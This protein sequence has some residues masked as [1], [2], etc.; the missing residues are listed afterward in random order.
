[1]K[2]IRRLLLGLGFIMVLL[3]VIFLQT[4][5]IEI[6]KEPF[7]LLKEMGA[8]LFVYALGYAA[9]FTIGGR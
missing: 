2:H 3:D 5:K 4:G 1:M 6:Y 9:D 8:W 7:N